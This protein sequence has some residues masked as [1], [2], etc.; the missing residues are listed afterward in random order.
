MQGLNYHYHSGKKGTCLSHRFTSTALVKYGH[1]PVPLEWRFKVSKPLA[2]EAYSYQTAT[3]AV[4]NIVTDYRKAQVAFAGFIVDGEIGRNEALE[5][6]LTEG[7]PVLIRAKNNMKVIFEGEALS[8]K[9]LAALFGPQ[10]CHLYSNVQWR[11]KRLSV[12]R[13]ST[14]FDVLIL[15]TRQFRKTLC[16]RL[17]TKFP[18]SYLQRTPHLR[19]HRAR[20]TLNSLLS[21]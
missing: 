14:T 3:Q 9:Q 19:L 21:V 2:T 10:R 4:K 8:L 15:S 18:A 20:Q 17:E 1:D 6:S 11:A 7:I 16:R 5:F 13:N 12:Q